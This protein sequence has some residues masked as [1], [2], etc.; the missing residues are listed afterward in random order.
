KVGMPDQR[1]LVRMLARR[2]AGRVHIRQNVDCRMAGM[3]VLVEH[4]HLQLAEA[5]A[6]GDLLRLVDALAGKDEKQMTVKR[7]ED[8]PEMF[9]VK[10]K[11]QIYTGYYGVDHVRQ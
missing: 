11:G 5:P 6:E 4:M 7:L 2:L 9:F 3:A 10:R 1:S 8:P